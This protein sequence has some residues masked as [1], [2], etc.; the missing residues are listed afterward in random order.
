MFF[1]RAIPIA[2]ASIML[3]SLGRK[4]MVTHIG[5]GFWQKYLCFLCLSPSIHG[6]AAPR[7]IIWFD[8]ATV[9]GRNPFRPRIE[10]MIETT[11]IVGI[12]VGE[13]NEKPCFLNGG[14]LDGFYPSTVS[15]RARCPS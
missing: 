14:V 12:Y 10:T 4:L 9:D 6:A 5:A 11:T 13:S 7:N 2:P 15:P 1:S 3:R 8:V